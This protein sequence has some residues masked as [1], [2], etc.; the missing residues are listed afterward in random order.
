MKTE[1]IEKIEKKGRLP[2]PTINKEKIEENLKTGTIR[3][4]N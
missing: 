2:D 4:R 3:K 1:S